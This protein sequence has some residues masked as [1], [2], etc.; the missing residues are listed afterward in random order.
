LAYELC[1]GAPLG[2]D[3]SCSNQYSPLQCN[4]DD[5]ITYMNLIVGRC[6]GKDMAF[7]GEEQFFE[8]E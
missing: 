4:V 3:P 7:S 1:D 2:E 6:L 8:N 5:H